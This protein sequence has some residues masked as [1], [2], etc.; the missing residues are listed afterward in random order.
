M[1]KRLQSWLGLTPY[2]SK[3]DL[4]LIKLNHPRRLLTPA[5]QQEASKHAA[6]AKARDEAVLPA[7][8]SKLWADF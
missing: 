8:P 6:I 4:F 5:E 7:Q 2:I 3:L 1:L